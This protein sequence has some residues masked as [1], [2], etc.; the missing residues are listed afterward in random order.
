MV[1]FFFICIVYRVIT[2]FTKTP[3]LITM[4]IGLISF[5]PLVRAVFVPK[6]APN[7]INTATNIP[8][9]N[10][11]LP[12]IANTTKAARNPAAHKNIILIKS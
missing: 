6:W 12:S 9:K 5:D 11:T 7:I 10:H 1:F 3:K 2:S 4:K 8:C